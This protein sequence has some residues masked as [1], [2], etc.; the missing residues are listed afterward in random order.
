MEA[1]A[2]G[3]DVPPTIASDATVVDDFDPPNWTLI[4][5]DF[6]LRDTASVAISR[7]LQSPAID[8][9]EDRHPPVDDARPLMALIPALAPGNLRPEMSPV[10]AKRTIVYFHSSGRILK[11]NGTPR[12]SC[13]TGPSSNGEKACL[14]Q[15]H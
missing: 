1:V 5:A 14:N 11:T 2:I 9:L 3:N 13:Y 7:T 12:S 8:G 4:K 6:L 10:L 15:S